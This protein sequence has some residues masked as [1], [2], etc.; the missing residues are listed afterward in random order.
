MTLRFKFVAEGVCK[1]VRVFVRALN[2][3]DD[4]PATPKIY[5]SLFSYF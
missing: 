4:L 1:R 3:C 2:I 5:Q